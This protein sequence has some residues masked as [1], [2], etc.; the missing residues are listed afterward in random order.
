MRAEWD[1]EGWYYGHD[2][3]TLGPLTAPQFQELLTRG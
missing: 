3:Q 1:S 2:G